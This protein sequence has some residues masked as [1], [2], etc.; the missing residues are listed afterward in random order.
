MRR[1]QFYL[2]RIRNLA[3]Q[4]ENADFSGRFLGQY[5][6]TVKWHSSNVERVFTLGVTED[7]RDLFHLEFEG[8]GRYFSPVEYQ[9]GSDVCILGGV[10]AEEL[11][12]IG[13]DPLDKEVNVNGRK[14]RV[15]GVLKKSGKDLLK[16]FNFDNGVLVSYTLAR[17][18]F[19]VREKGGLAGTSLLV[20]AKPGVSLDAMKDDIIGV[21][22]GTAAETPRRE[23]LRTQYPVYSQRLFDSVFSTLNLA[24]FIIG[25]FALIVGMFLVQHHVRFSKRADQHYRHQDGT[26]EQN[27][28]LSC[29]KSCLKPW[30]CASCG[31]PSGW[32]SSG[33]SPRGISKAMDFDIHLSFEQ[34]ADRAW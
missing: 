15:L 4:L 24:G 19:G 11:F 10:I 17:R 13:I 30:Y 33:W 16:P 5:R 6:Q 21:L 23:Q 14:L 12:G 28:G 27:A 32:C 26:G 7:C 3:R 8:E 34:C 1:P 9:S 2:P 22:R 31:G 29:W 18:G 20:K 25:V